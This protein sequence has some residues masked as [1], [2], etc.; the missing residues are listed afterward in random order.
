MGSDG[1]EEGFKGVDLVCGLRRVG[2]QVGIV[3][4]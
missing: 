3:V 1:D 4:Y 2:V